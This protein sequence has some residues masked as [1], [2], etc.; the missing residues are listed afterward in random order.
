MS[1][2]HEYAA[3]SD[4]DLAARFRSGERDVSFTI[5]V[6]RY[7][8]RIY[9]SAKRLANGDHDEADDI[10]QE[11]FVKMYEALEN[12]RG[13]SKLFTWVYRIM[14]NNVIHR[15][16][17]KRSSSHIPLEEISESIGTEHT[18]VDGIE[19]AETTKLI[20]EAIG[21]LPPKQREVFLMRFYDELPYDE[22]AKILGTSVG[23][24]KANY[25]HAVQKIG[26]YLKRQGSINITA[27]MRTD[28]Q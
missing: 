13:E 26:D 24:L 1:L 12:F 8:K 17:K 18:P 21:T 2:R 19:G 10:T 25:F 7:Q 20:E 6:E 4:E 15:S 9:L 3:L 22:I 5:L 28:E 14:M 16:R 27:Y 11:T 23:G